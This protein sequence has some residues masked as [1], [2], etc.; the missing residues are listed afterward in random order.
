MAKYKVS[1]SG[2]AY[3]E[4][5]SEESALEA[6]FDGETVYDESGVDNVVEVYEFSV[7]V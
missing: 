4:A 3:V 7:E 1:F 5:Q 6:Y 2:F